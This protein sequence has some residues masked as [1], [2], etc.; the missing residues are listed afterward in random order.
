[1]KSDFLLFAIGV[2]AIL[3]MG[4]VIGLNMLYPNGVSH[5]QQNARISV[6]ASGIAYG[7]PQAATLY[8]LI[9]GSGNTPEIATSNLSLSLSAFNSTVSKYIGGNLSRI[10][11]QSYSL[12]KV[13]N[14]TMYQASEYVSVSIP[15]IASISS[16]LGALSTINNVYINQVSADLSGQ[17]VAAMTNEALKLALQN[18]TAQAQTL[19][20]N[21]TLTIT[22]ISTIQSG[23]YPSYRYFSAAANTAGGNPI[24]FSG[25]QAVE[26]TVNV[27]FSYT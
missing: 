13:Y 9:N 2:F 12:Q 17:Q 10:T 5:G 23:P 27:Q 7:S 18:A 19:A 20:G 6:S 3:V 1:M 24:Y 26:E 11:T 4:V 16:L 8:V 25:R 14:T 21:S 15:N 22:N